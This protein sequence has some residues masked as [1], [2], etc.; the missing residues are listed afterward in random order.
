MG[1]IFF[2]HLTCMSPPLHMQVTSNIFQCQDNPGK[3]I[4]LHTLPSNPSSNGLPE[5]IASAGTV[6]GNSERIEE[7][8]E[9]EKVNAAMNGIAKAKC[10]STQIIPRL[11]S[12]VEIIKRE[13][14]KSKEPG[15]QNTGLYQYNYL[16][17]LEE[18]KDMSNSKISD[19][20]VRQKD[21]AAV[22]EGQNL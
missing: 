5:V 12:V 16:G 14:F 2:K 4:I 7:L 22:L 10:N 21:I 6:Q 19:E 13:Y 20:D 1:W 17:F 3:P 18:S 9:E 8:P 15:L 11:I